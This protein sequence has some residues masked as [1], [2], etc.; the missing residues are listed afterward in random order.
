MNKAVLFGRLFLRCD[1][2]V[3]WLGIMADY[4]MLSMKEVL[5]LINDKCNYATD[6]FSIEALR[7]YVEEYINKSYEE[8]YGKFHLQMK[9][10]TK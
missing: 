2:I 8:K 3:L 1:I 6:P 9:K 7:K 5:E 10:K 4:E